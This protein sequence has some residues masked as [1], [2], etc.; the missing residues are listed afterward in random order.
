MRE[1]I[2]VAHV[3][4]AQSQDLARYHHAVGAVAD[5]E[6]IVLIANMEGNKVYAQF[7]CRQKR[8]E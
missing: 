6:V 7:E 2:D 4:P 5:L 1:K 8:M 3:L